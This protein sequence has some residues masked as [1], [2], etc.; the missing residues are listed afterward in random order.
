MI[1][2]GN[3]RPVRT[4]TWPAVCRNSPDLIRRRYAYMYILLKSRAVRGHSGRPSTVKLPV[5]E[6]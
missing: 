5:R 1:D 6:L 2:V 4:T 3:R